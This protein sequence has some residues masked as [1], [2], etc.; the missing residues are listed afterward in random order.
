M[1]HSRLL[2]K[3][4]KQLINSNTG[5][6]AIYTAAFNAAQSRLMVHYSA[7][8]V[9]RCRPTARS[10]NLKPNRTN[11][12]VAEYVVAIDVTRAQFPADAYLPKM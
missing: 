12:L 6:V 4:E 9:G 1:G 8:V 7:V 5:L 11:G 2:A 3:H 10:K